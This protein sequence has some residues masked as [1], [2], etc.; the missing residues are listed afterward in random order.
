[1]DMAIAANLFMNSPREPRIWRCPA[2]RWGYP[3][4]RSPRF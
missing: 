1:V 4:F 3:R 2:P